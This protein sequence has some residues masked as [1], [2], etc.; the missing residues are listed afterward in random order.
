[1]LILIFGNP[2]YREL[3]RH[4]RGPIS[5]GM[6]RSRRAQATVDVVKTNVARAV[7][8]CKKSILYKK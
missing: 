4:C 7:E 8:A 1:V 3:A 5:G 6:R 2:T